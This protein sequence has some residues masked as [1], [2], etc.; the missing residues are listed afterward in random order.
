MA[1]R[2]TTYG[3]R[4]PLKGRAVEQALDIEAGLRTPGFDFQR[5]VAYLETSLGIETDMDILE[6]IQGAIWYAEV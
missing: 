5:F 3:T 4:V 6:Q 1:R 2:L